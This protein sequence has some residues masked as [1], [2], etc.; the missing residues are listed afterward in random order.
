VTPVPKPAARAPTVRKP[1]KRVNKVRKAKSFARSYH[2]VERV[3]WIKRLPCACCSY[4]GAEPCENAHL[5]HPD[6]GTGYK[7][8]WTAIVPLCHTCHEAKVYLNDPAYYA[9]VA[10]NLARV[11]T[12]T[13]VAT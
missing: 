5:P 6:A 7:G 3:D 1:V 13:G 2:S 4:N 9:D 8:P 11:W 12:P 10:A